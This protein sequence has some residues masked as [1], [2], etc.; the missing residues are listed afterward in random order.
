MELYNTFVIVQD[1]T[2]SKGKECIDGKS[3]VVAVDT[4]P[5]CCSRA[6]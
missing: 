6:W 5:W 4:D 2:C 3:L 1:W